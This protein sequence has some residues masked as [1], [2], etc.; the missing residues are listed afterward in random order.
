MISSKA[1][2]R[3]QLSCNLIISGPAHPPKVKYSQSVP[4]LVIKHTGDT[5]YD[6]Y[7]AETL[8][9][10]RSA[11]KPRKQTRFESDPVT[12]VRHI[13]ARCRQETSPPKRT[14]DPLDP[15]LLI[16]IELSQ[17]TMGACVPRPQGK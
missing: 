12:S 14:I 16:Q 10:L 4:K 7:I 11:F 8:I 1:V 15:D 3:L 9:P 17:A 6:S 2:S 5:A 13:P